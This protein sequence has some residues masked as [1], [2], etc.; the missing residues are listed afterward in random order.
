MYLLLDTKTNTRFNTESILVLNEWV[1]LNINYPYASK[2]VKQ[3]L[4]VKNNL[5]IQQIENW[6]C[7]TR[8]RL[9]ILGITDKNVEYWFELE[10]KKALK[11]NKY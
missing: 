9:Q 11:K 2:K 8:K 4:A 10:K 5:T 6:L 3:E 1:R 7:H